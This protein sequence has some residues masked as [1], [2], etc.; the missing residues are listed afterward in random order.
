MTGGNVTVYYHFSGLRKIQKHA[1]D[2]C[3]WFDVI[4]VDEGSIVAG[5]D[6]DHQCSANFYQFS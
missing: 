6:F 3:Q 2:Y 4:D 1:I 5:I